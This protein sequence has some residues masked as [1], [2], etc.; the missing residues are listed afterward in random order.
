MQKHTLHTSHGA[1]FQRTSFLI[2]V[3]IWYYCVNWP[4]VAQNPARTCCHHQTYLPT[5]W[6]ILIKHDVSKNRQTKKVSNKKRWTQQPNTLKLIVSKTYCTAKLSGQKP[7]VKLHSKPPLEDVSWKGA[8]RGQL[9][10]P[11]NHPQPHPQ[12]NHPGPVVTREHTKCSGDFC[13]V[14]TDFRTTTTTYL[15][16]YIIWYLYA[17]IVEQTIPEWVPKKSKMRFWTF[18]CETLIISFVQ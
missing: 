2:P 14:D 16:I 18:W 12:W 9:N 10:G 13:R 8:E 11:T 4:P 15:Y 1:C 7:S 17:E 5:K 6:I 3:M